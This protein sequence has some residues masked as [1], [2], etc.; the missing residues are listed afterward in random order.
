MPTMINSNKMTLKYITVKLVKTIGKK[1]LKSCK[2][3]TDFMG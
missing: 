1:N 3:K 2:G